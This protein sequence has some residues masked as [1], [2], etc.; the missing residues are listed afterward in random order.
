MSVMRSAQ[1]AETAMSRGR[2]VSA[3]L[4]PQSNRTYVGRH[5]TPPD[6]TPWLRLNPKAPH[7][8]YV[9]GAWWLH[10]DDLSAELP[11]LL[12]VLSVRLHARPKGNH[13]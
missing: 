10:S 11:D 9:D 8:G 12:A 2:E 4:A 3:T 13:G 7:T 6:H 1:A 5:L